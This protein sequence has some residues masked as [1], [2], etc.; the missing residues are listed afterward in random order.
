VQFRFQG[1]G[2]AFD[3]ELTSTASQI[4]GKWTQVGI[5]SLTLE[6]VNLK[7][8]RQALDAGR[9]Y[10]YTNEAELQGHWTGVLPGKHGIQLRVVFHVAQ[11]SDGSYS[12]TLD[13]P[14]QLL[15]AMPFDVIDFVPPRVRL[16]IKSAKCTFEGR[17]SEGKV[18]GTWT[19]DKRISQPLTLERKPSG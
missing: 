15:F 16:E 8:E 1:L 7:D 19:Y 3:G 4:I 9:N 13:S 14:D 12:A 10:R 17:L 18:S 6:R 11:L 2:A 5:D